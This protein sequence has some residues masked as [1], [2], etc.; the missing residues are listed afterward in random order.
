MDELEAAPKP[1]LALSKKTKTDKLAMIA[2]NL[3]ALEYE[4]E[5]MRMTRQATRYR[6]AVR[7]VMPLDEA[8]YGARPGQMG[9]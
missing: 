5:A 4:E 1:A 7:A 9:G 2:V 8:P 6:L 3:A